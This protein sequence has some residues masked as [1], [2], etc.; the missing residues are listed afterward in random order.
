MNRLPN[1]DDKRGV[2][3]LK[4]EQ[5][6]TKKDENVV[7][8]NN[9]SGPKFPNTN[10]RFCGPNNAGP[11]FPN[12]VPGPGFSNVEQG[13]NIACQIL[14]LNNPVSNIK[15]DEQDDGG[16]IEDL[17]WMPLLNTP[18]PLNAPPPLI[19]QPPVFRPRGS[20]PKSWRGPRR[21][22]PPRFRPSGGGPP[23]ENFQ[24]THNVGPRPFF[25]GNNNWRP[26][27]NNW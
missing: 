18:P 9:S 24:Q 13:N 21:G 22:M 8:Q 5:H 6:L 14:D 23:S 1:E 4:T 10:S 11:R 15:N 25:R 16:V 19:S 2:P 27:F 12:P 3:E 20:G 17:T 7:P 26:H